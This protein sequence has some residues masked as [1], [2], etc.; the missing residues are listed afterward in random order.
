MASENGFNHPTFRY[1]DQRADMTRPEMTV[2]YGQGRN[3]PTMTVRTANVEVPRTQSTAPMMN[4]IGYTITRALIMAA[5]GT[6]MTMSTFPT[7]MPVHQH[8]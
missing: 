5:S 4:T 3:L 7:A 6:P 1:P 2:G 8:N